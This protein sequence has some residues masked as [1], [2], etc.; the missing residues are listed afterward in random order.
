MQNKFINHARN[1]WERGIKWMPRVDQFWFK[2]I[3]MEEM[4]GQ[5]IKARAI[6]EKWMSWRPEGKAWM[7]YVRFEER[8]H[9]KEKSRKVM[10]RYLDCHP[11]LDT[12]LKVAKYEIKLRNYDDSRFIFEKTLNDLGELAFTEHFFIQWAKFELRS[13]ELNR[14]RD[15]FKYGLAN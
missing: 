11:S 2:Y 1:I 13:N 8:M 6:F 12:Y 10:Y 3:Y 14:A 9:E 15:I 7:A 4:L 5:Y